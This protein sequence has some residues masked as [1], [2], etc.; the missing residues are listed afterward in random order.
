ME[1]LSKPKR[2]KKEVSEFEEKL[3]KELNNH[4]KSKID[5]MIK[6]MLKRLEEKLKDFLNKYE[7]KMLAELKNSNETMNKF[8]EKISSLEETF[9]L[10]YSSIKKN[11]FLY[12]SNSKEWL[13]ENH[14]KLKEEIEN[15]RKEK[16]DTESD[17]KTGISPENTGS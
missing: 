4:F 12:A 15:A 10:L 9:L 2:A 11:Q 6:I 7:V 14:N 5:G 16:L 13:K 17:K 3:I 1:N 8:C